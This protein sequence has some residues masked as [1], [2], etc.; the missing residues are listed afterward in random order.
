MPQVRL[1]RRALRAVFAVCIAILSIAALNVSTPASA[2]AQENSSA[3]QSATDFDSWTAIADEL[4]T[5]L[6]AGQSAYRDGN[7][8]Q[9]ASAFSRALN[10]DFVAS[11]FAKITNDTQGAEQY[12][13]LLTQLRSLTRLAYTPGHDD[14]IAATV[15][16]LDTSVHEIAAQCDT[17]ASLQSPRAYAQARTEQTQAER[18]VLD[19]NKVRVNEGRGERTWS[20]VAQEMTAILD[21]AQADAEAGR[22]EEGAAGV[23]DAYYQYYEKLGFEKNVMNAIGGSRVSKVESTF[24]EARKAMVKGEDSQ[25]Y[26]TQLTTMLTEDAA[27]LDGGAA[28]DAQGFT[29]LVTSAAG[30]AFL[31]LIREGLEALLVVAAVIAYLLRTGLRS[32]TRW[33]YAGAVV[34]LLGSGVIAV[35]FMQLFGGSGPQQEIM[36]G[37]CALIAAAMLAWSGNWMFSKRSA[38]SWNSYIHAKTQNAVQVAQTSASR[39]VFSLAVLSFLAVFR[40][41]AETVIFYESIFSMTQDSRGMWIGGLLAAFALAI[42][43][44]IIRLT[45]VKLP[46]GPFFTVTSVLMTALAVVFVGSGVHALIEGDAISGTYIEGA[47]TNDWLGIYPYTQTLVAQAV[48]AVL[49]IAMFVAAIITQHRKT[50]AQ[51]AALVPAESSAV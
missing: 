19:A 31:V 24:K 32:Y 30:Q 1:P 25:E 47:P 36:E 4:T 50:S 27:A 35:I 45:S 34:G 18:E 49:L 51:S 26:I 5:Q 39:A 8:A 14:E 12:Q 10:T 20:Q 23:N 9:A 41:G 40:E 33:V 29:A 7:A 2:W 22:G 21:Q 15:T 28:S 38:D 43:F 42:L 13:N 48:A 11:N 6:E 44:V 37:C 46:I 16:A 3:A 17:N